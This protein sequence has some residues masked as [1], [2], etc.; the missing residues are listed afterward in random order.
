MV[1]R[2]LVAA[3]V[4]AL[5]VF[6]AGEPSPA[7]TPPH[8]RVAARA[9][10]AAAVRP[11]PGSVVRAFDPPATRFGAGHRGVDLRAT[12]GE[13]VVAAMGGTVTFAG[14]VAGVGWIT[15]DHGAGLST[16]YGPI[17][18]RLVGAGT[19]VAAGEWLG[20]LAAG[21][22][23]LD[24]GARLDGG[25]IDP[26]GLL[27]RWETYLTT[28]DD[29]AGLPV[30]GGVAAAGAGRAAPGRLAVPA[31][32]PRTSDFGMRTHP[33]TGE[34][35]LH[36]GLDIAG[37]AGAPIRAAAAGAVT[38]AGSLSGYGTTVTIDH[39]GG[40]STLYAHQSQVA[41][42][43]GQQVSAGQVIGRIGA[44]GLV[45][46]PHLHFEVRAGGTPQDPAGWL[47]R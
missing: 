29:S 12:A 46:G 11:V 6:L 17:E 25:Y 4:A 3:V 22:K 8:D 32:G 10:S 5:L 20:F 31:A 41:V 45:T 13:P 37:P 15:V 40:I 47:A 44:T 38:F 30:L 28:P 21:A 18:P 19:V 27:G 24:W 39:G 16:T 23:H 43:A 36:A 35:R 42:G 34:Q 2:A 1:A 26:V 33:V 7:K 9:V 14:L